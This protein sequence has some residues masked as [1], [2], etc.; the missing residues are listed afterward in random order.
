MFELIIPP[1]L[2]VL[3]YLSQRNT[4]CFIVSVYLNIPIWT[5]GQ[6][7]ERAYFQYACSSYYIKQLREWTKVNSEPAIKLDFAGK[8]LSLSTHSVNHTVTNQEHRFYRRCR[9]YKPEVSPFK[10]LTNTVNA[11]SSGVE[12]SLL[13]SETQVPYSFLLQFLMDSTVRLRINEERVIRHRYQPLQ[14]LVAEPAHFK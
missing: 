11:T 5:H 4:W 6:H 9:N 7:I 13:N 1:K 8:Y 14:A 10:L 3:V 12:G 2:L